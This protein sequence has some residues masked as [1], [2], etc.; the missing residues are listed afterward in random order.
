MAGK[1]YYLPPI[2]Y[3]SGKVYGKKYDFTSVYRKASQY[4]KRCA[5]VG[6]RDMENKPYSPA[7]LAHQNQFKAVVKATRERMQ[8]M[9]KKEQDIRAFKEQTQYHSFYRFV[10]NQ[11][12]TDYQP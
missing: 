8:D 4:P 1:V 12:W 2:D 7:E 9:S 3:T 11:E 6:T 10:F 5:T